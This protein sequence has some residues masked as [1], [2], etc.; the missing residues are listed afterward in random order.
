MLGDRLID[1][2]RL[3]GLV[4]AAGYRGLVEAAGYRGLHECRIC[5]SRG[6]WQR[7]PDEVLRVMKAR[8]VE[9]C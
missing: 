3:R 8:H 4:E 5:S 7:D 2:R 1:L 9:H 6:G